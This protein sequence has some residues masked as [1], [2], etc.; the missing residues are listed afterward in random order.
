MLIASGD[1]SMWVVISRSAMEEC[2][3]GKIGEPAYKRLFFAGLRVYT[4]GVADGQWKPG[5]IATSQNIVKENGLTQYCR[6]GVI[7]DPWLSVGEH[8]SSIVYGEGSYEGHNEDD[9]LNFGG[10]NVSKRGGLL[11]CAEA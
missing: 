10:S 3:S 5:F 2:S 9:A 1:F 8:P 7:E 4:G 6:K 11:C